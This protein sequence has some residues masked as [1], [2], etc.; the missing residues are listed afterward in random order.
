M[1]E[2]KERLISA[3]ERPLSRIKSGRSTAGDERD[4]ASAY[5]K[6]VQAGYAMQIKK[7]YRAK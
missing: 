6:L 1:S 5:Q 3:V 7:K 2:D 4:Y